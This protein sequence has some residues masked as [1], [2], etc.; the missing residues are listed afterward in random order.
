MGFLIEWIRR[1]IEA[2]LRVATGYITELGEASFSGFIKFVLFLPLAGHRGSTD[3]TLLH[4]ARLVAFRHEDCGSCL[5]GAINVALDEGVAP[6]SIAAVLDGNHSTMPPAVS[7]IVRFTEGVLAMDSSEC[8]PRQEILA[9]YGVTTLA[10]L[11]LAI[12]SARVFP[13][14]KRGLGHSVSCDAVKPAIFIKATF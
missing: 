13:T 7:L 6:S 11:S 14:V 1:A 4:V 2:R 3:S 10:E 12:A 8:E 9:R 5:Q